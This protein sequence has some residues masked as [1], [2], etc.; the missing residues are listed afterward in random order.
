VLLL[1][2][3]TEP[4]VEQDARIAG[5]ALE[6]GKA[7]VVLVNKWDKLPAAKAEAFRKELDYQ[8]PFIS[9][10]PVI[11]GSALTGSKVF[12]A[13][14]KCGEIFEQYKARVPTPLVNEFMQRI[15]DEH[16]APRA[17][18]GQPVRIFYIA[19]IGIR[20]PMFSLMC[21]RPEGVSDDYKRFIVNRMR[22]AF[23][24]RV[25]I[26]LIFKRKSKRQFHFKKEPRR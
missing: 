15:E 4:A 23:G 18:G 14:R 13:L 21:N 8:M 9:W 6:K 2:D 22:E 26:R 3:A 12:E 16:P 20:P 25:P 24:L 19:Q 17:K 5:L 7:L 1:L 11:F 10:A